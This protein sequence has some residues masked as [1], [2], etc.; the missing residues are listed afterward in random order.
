MLQMFFLKPHTSYTKQ[1][2]A[3][4]KNDMCVPG[5]LLQ[6]AS[7]GTGNMRGV[8]SNHKQIHSKDYQQ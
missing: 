7:A 4:I 8:R 1:Y 3:A 5:K 2:P 6:Y